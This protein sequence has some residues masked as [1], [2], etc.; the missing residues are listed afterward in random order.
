MA[1][2]KKDATKEIESLDDEVLSAAENT[3]NQDALETVAE[4]KMSLSFSEVTEDGLGETKTVSVGKTSSAKKPAGS[5]KITASGKATSRSRNEI[6]M[7]KLSDLVGEEDAKKMVGLID[8]LPKKVQDKARNLL[9]AATGG[10]N[11]SNYTRYALS[12][13]AASET[14]EVKSTDIFRYLAE[15]R[16]YSEGTARSQAKQIMTLLPFAGVA[17]RSG[18]LLKVNTESEIY[19]ALSE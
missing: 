17:E 13:L 10:A 1:Q 19:K 2:K 15:D 7:K 5:K 18:S 9:I 3:G 16:K 6:D 14:G 12:L 11:L 8:D 4:G